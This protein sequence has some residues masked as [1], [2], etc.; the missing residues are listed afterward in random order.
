MSA[1]TEETPVEWN[2]VDQAL[3]GLLTFLLARKTAEF[4]GLPAWTG[5]A[6]AAIGIAAVTDERADPRL[7]R[8][9]L[10]LTKPAAT[11]VGILKSNSA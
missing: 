6:A 5:G 7:R 11:V 2:A 3:A 1:D 8:F 4:V 9:G 10:V